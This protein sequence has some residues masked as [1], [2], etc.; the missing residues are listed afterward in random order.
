MLIWGVEGRLKE[1]M[2]EGREAGQELGTVEVW[3]CLQT[4]ALAEVKC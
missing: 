1:N 2:K 3:G 4:A